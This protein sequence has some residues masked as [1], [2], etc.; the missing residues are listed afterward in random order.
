[1]NTSL[2][3]AVNFFPFFFEVRALKKAEDIM[4][5]L[6]HPLHVE[7]MLQP[8]GCRYSGPKYRTVIKIFCSS[9]PKEQNSLWWLVVYPLHKVL[10]NILYLTIFMSFYFNLLLWFIYIYLYL[11]IFPIARGKIYFCLKHVNYC[12]LF[13]L[14]EKPEF[15]FHNLESNPFFFF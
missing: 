2:V 7:F 10:L 3:V 1:M 12:F 9:L 11:F 4:S 5:D 14:T 15:P 8:Y 6:S 13:V